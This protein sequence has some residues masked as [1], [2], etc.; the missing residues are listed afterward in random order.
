MD[1]RR[2][3]S[4]AQKCPGWKVCRRKRNLL[5][6]RSGSGR[7]GA[8]SGPSEGLRH[9]TAF[10][11]KPICRMRSRSPKTPH[12]V[13]PASNGSRSSRPTPPATCFETFC[14]SRGFSGSLPHVK[15]PSGMPCS[16]A[17]Q[18]SAV[19]NPPDEPLKRIS[20]SEAKPSHSSMKE[21]HLMSD[22]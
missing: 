21:P 9:H 16:N 19:H 22:A 10:R 1:Q 2:I 17:K 5:P 13:T 12:K 15:H 3:F 11:R 18:D 4:A 7:S 14:F 20:S 6:E 8:V